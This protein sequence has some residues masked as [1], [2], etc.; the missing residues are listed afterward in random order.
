MSIELLRRVS[1][2]LDS[3]G[4]LDGYIVKYYRW[5]DQDLRGDGQVLLFRM[6]GTGGPNAHV[7]Q[8]LDVTVQM[9]CDP[10]QVEFGDRRMLE[11]VRYLRANFETTDAFNMVP[12]DP[13]TGPTYLQNNRARFEL[14]V[15]TMVTDH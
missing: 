9:L 8:V 3:A 5:S 15:R 7:I 11:I 2:H 13:Y 4:L 10:G 12:V 6:S 14:I 1:D